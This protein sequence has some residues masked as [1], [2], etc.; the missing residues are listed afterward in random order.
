MPG[1]LNCAVI[2]AQHPVAGDRS[3]EHLKGDRTSP[4]LRFELS[5]TLK[6]HA[7]R[8][9][10]SSLFDPPRSLLFTRQ[11]S[12]SNVRKPQQNQA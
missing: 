9:V 1:P 2:L 4:D 10:N 7:L 8:R 11:R 5:K 3:D 12:C 6:R